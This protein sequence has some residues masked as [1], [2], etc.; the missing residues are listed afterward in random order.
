[1]N[2]AIANA[3]V[4]SYPDITLPDI[5]SKPVT[6]SSVDSKLVLVH[7][8][9]ASNAA[10]KMF[11]VEALL[12]LYEEF[13]SKGLEIYSICL[14][15]DKAEW[16]STVTAQ[17][18]PWINVNDGKGANCPAVTLYSVANLPTSFFIR[19]GELV[20]DTGSIKSLGDLRKTVA[21]MLK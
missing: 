16:G 1:M 9:D 6:L 4:F 3:P 8:W 21:R 11:N 15:T 14:D 12:P 20:T 2:T 7:F 19:E 5:S 10:Q 17:K 18:L 13:H